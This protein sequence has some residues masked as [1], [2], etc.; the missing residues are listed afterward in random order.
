MIQYR[1][2]IPGFEV[3][4]NAAKGI[5]VMRIHYTA[6]PAKRHPSWAETKKKRYPSERDWNREMELDWSS[7]GGDPYY[8]AC[9]EHPERYIWRGHPSIVR[10]L[11]VIRCWD[12]GIRHPACVWLQ[13][14]P[15]SDRVRVLREALGTGIDIHA[16]RDIVLY[17]SGELSKDTLEARPWA[18]KA[19]MFLQWL[20]QD[21]RYPPTP[22]FDQGI[23]FL[24]YAGH[25]AVQ[26]YSNIAS[27]PEEKS[28]QHV[29]AAGGINL[30]C[31]YTPQ[32]ARSTVIRRLLHMREDGLPGLLFDEPCPILIEGF[33]GGQ[34]VFDK[35]TKQ[36]PDPTEPMKDDWYSNLHEAAGYGI[37][38]V[39]PEDAP[40]G[41]LAATA[42]GGYTQAEADG[43][44]IHEVLGR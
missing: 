21:E 33:C 30:G 9:V 41:L 12:F 38:N 16:W 24:D 7:P 18:E 14:S 19:L 31:F 37:V 39:V 20:R 42:G 17:L 15:R 27:A 2:D 8:A 32:A 23:R 1:T 29:L 35:P 13:Y 3:T 5:T 43:L 44:L 6:D 40:E 28:A 22:W 36:N 4:R 34:I 11:P 10:G 25:E 26:R